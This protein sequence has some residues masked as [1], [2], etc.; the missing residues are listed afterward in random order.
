MVQLRCYTDNTKNRSVFDGL[1]KTCL[2]HASSHISEGRL[3]STLYRMPKSDIISFVNSNEKHYAVHL[4]F[5]VANVQEAHPEAT[6]K[7][8]SAF[9]VLVPANICQVDKTMVTQ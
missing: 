5:F 6:E 3:F 9:S 1:H 8:R 7:H 2:A 4:T